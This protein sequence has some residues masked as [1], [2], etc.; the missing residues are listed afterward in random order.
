MRFFTDAYDLVVIGI[1]STLIAK[2]RHPGSGIVR[3]AVM[4]GLGGGA[5][6]CQFS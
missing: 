6:S 2:P 5:G 4:D 1:A 3:I